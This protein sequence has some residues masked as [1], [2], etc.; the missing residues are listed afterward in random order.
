MNFFDDL[1]NDFNNC[2]YQLSHK[3]Y[4]YN[5]ANK[6][7]DSGQNELVM[8]KESAYELDG[9][10]FNLITSKSFEDKITVIGD[11]LA[12]IN[13]DRRFARICVISIEDVDDEQKAYDLIRKI[14]YVK[15]H[16]F[17]KG[18]MIRTSSRSH[19]E[20][21][22]LSKSAVNSGA[23]FEKIGNLLIDKYKENPAVKAVHLFFV[24]EKS[25]NYKKLEALAVKNHS[26]T[27]TLNHIMNN[28][29]FDCSSCNLKPICDEVEGMRE[30]HFKTAGKHGM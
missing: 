24:T 9:V 18:Y 6:W 12:Q 2:V 4:S 10:G 1:I 19:K 3:D 25:V 21:V 23:C 27:E 20:V 13:G 7:Q 17:P 15:Y 5:S 11:D 8:Q 26:I 14:E 30:L 16:F 28:V 29:N 22:R